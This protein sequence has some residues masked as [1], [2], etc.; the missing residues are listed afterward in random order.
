MRT[1]IVTGLAIT[2][3]V[4]LLLG[5]ALLAR[6]MMW[7]VTDFIRDNGPP[8]R[9]HSTALSAGIWLFATFSM[10]ATLAPVPLYERAAAI[11]MMS[12]LL[13]AGIT[14]ALSGYLPRTFTARLLLAGLLWEM[15][16]GGTPAGVCEQLIEVTVMAGAM[17]V[18][19][20]LVNRRVQRLGHGDLWLIT[21]LTAWMG[22]KAVALATLCGLAGFVLWLMTLHL[23]GKKEGPLGPWLCL[24]GSFF[25]LFHLY[26][27]VWITIL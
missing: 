9:R 11:V 15:L 24:S 14:D 16:P 27:P 13:Q 17:L 25:Q 6:G 7:R 18:L 1:V 23:S 10:L 5:Y 26:Q 8:G 12:F 2:W 21:G 3:S 4:P 19:N 20:A 22:M